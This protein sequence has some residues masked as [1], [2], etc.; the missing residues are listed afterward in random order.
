MKTKILLGKLASWFQVLTALMSGPVAAQFLSDKNEVSSVRGSAATS[1]AQSL[2]TCRELR[3]RWTVRYSPPTGSLS[4]HFV[5]GTEK[6]VW[7]QGDRIEE[8]SW[9]PDGSN[10]LVV[11]QRGDLDHLASSLWKIS[12]A[13][14]R[15][16]A[17]LELVP[18]HHRRPASSHYWPDG[19]E[20][21]SLGRWSPDGRRVTFWTGPNSCSVAADGLPLSVVDVG[22]GKVS[23]LAR[24][25]LVNLRYQSWATDGSRLVFTAGGGRSAQ[26]HK[27]LC[28]W[29]AKT[30][31][32]RT[33]IK[34]GE[35]VPGIVAWAPEGPRIAYAACSAQNEDDGSMTFA[36]PAIA[37]RRV[38]LLNCDTGEHHRLNG[39]E[40]YQ[41]APCWAT[42]GRALLYVELHKDAVGLMSADPTTRAPRTLKEIPVPDQVGYYGQA[43]W[44]GLLQQRDSGK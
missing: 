13:L 43:D 17:P 24:T 10:L 27:W 28:V 8:V 16:G 2:L 12:V 21:I 29:D 38:Y 15:V 14:D 19:L 3:G 41:D 39:V 11:K 18:G 25:A 44:D 22:S 35:Q 42:S 34:E 36:N 9:S 6:G 33:V 5:N 30:R 40:S 7:A 23:L 37:K 26:T 32:T 20:I 31:R 4:I 1:A